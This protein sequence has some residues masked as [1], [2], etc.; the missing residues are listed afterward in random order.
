METEQASMAEI[1]ALAQP[2]PLWKRPQVVHLL[3][4]ALFA[5]IG[6]AVLN[7]STMPVYLASKVADGGRGLGESSVGLVLTAFLMSEAVFKGPMGHLA[8]K[9]GR[10]RLMMIGP[11]LTIGTSVLTLAVPTSPQWLSV[12]L[13]MCLRI[14]DGIG[15]AMLWPGAF[16][17]MGDA[18]ED[19]QRQQAMSLLNV[20][21]LLGV[22]LAL[23][24][25]GGV[26]VLAGV[27]WASLLLA[28]VL[29]AG[30]L[31]TTWKFL[32]RDSGHASHGPVEGEAAP[33]M[34]VFRSAKQ[35]P[36][37][38]ILAVVTFAG[39]GFPMAIIKNFAL[40]EFNMNE[41]AFG[42]LVLPAALAMALLSVPMSKLGER[43]GRSRAVHLGMGLCSG[44]L[45]FIALGAIIPYLRVPW[46]LALGGL[47]VGIGFLLAIPAWMASVSDANPNRRAANL[48][49]VMTAQGVGAI[50]GAPIGAVC[51]EKL[52][53]LGPGFVHFGRYSPFVG[54]A[55][56]V[57]AGWIVGMKILR[58]PSAQT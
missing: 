33:L 14:L 3:I 21:Y 47:P 57:T 12:V 49:A 37:Y 34:E 52:Q 36:T 55:M 30:V 29:F 26:N 44:G 54:C 10:R 8:D 24:I 16:A 5:E 13:F 17:S 6:Y 46:A 48:G 7:I 4:I 19:G 23:P 18:V 1:P 51:Y 50:I 20:C 22:A 28:T 40:D 58:D 53:L 32:P 11:A 35:I 25:G 31:F 9:Y 38:L 56:C 45:I 41:F 15:A 42:L 43:L 2:S 39:I 27:K